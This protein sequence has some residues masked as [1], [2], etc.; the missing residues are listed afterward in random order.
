MM[1]TRPIHDHFARLGEGARRT[2]STSP[3]GILVRRKNGIDGLIDKADFHI[4][5]LGSGV[6]AR[7][8][9]I[10]VSPSE[11]SIAPIS[12]YCPS[13]NWNME[14]PAARE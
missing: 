9:E 4:N 7:Q 10:R 14:R 11:L 12:A 6:G 8:Q 13:P 1:M 2:I 3:D 5:V